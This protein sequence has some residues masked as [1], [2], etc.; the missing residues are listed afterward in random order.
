VIELPEISVAILAGGLGTRLR[1]AVADRPKVLAPVAGR[2]YLSHL[3]EYL[4]RYEVREVVLLVGHRAD[5][6]HA[7]LGDRHNGVR[8]NYSVEETP[9]GTGGAV[10]L[11]L[12][13]LRA[14]HV[15]LLNGDSLCDANL[16]AFRREHA[17]RGA[18]VGMVLARV[19]DTAR[20]GSV[21]LNAEG[22]VV[23][24]A[25]KTT[26]GPGWINAGVYLLA[27]DL[28]ADAPAHRPLSLER[29]L[30]PEWVV[31]GKVWGFPG[32]GRFLDIGT[33]ESYATAEA[34]FARVCQGA[35]N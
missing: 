3:I 33:P 10:R 32:R 12:P 8:L 1:P 16:N 4:A 34:F 21:M 22:C 2:P 11:A 35:A 6:V 19:S 7:A 14:P 24:F 17:R 27:R 9:L 29:D 30:M 15:L 28:I 26:T 31:A 23:R 5:E 18:E 13:L 20:F 25:E